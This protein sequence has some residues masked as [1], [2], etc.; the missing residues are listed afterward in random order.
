MLELAIGVVVVVLVLANGGWDWIK[1]KFPALQS[2]NAQ[3]VKDLDPVK[4][5]VAKVVDDVHALI[6]NWLALCKAPGIAADPAA[7]QALDVIKNKILT[8]SLPKAP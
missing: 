4:Q 8:P 2:A 7:V 6:D 3:V 1:T 5:D